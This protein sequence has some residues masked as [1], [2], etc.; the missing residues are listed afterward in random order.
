MEFDFQCLSD[1]PVEHRR[2][3]GGGYRS[4][5]FGVRIEDASQ[6]S[7]LKIIRMANLGD[8]P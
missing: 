7:K 1:G 2:Y 3:D 6:P 4:S 8:P 5:Y